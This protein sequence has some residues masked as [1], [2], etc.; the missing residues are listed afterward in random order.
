MLS[1]GTVCI[2]PAGHPYFP[3]RAPNWIILSFY[4]YTFFSPTMS[5]FVT[6]G[7]IRNKE[8]ALWPAMSLQQDHTEDSVQYCKPIYRGSPK[9]YSVFGTLEPLKGQYWVPMQWSYTLVNHV[10]EPCVCVLSETRQEIR[11]SPW[12]WWL[13]HITRSFPQ[14]ANRVLYYSWTGKHISQS[15]CR[16]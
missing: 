3:L 2:Y 12:L 5:F 4:F 13:W 14:K 8:S 16:A 9:A 10:V 6:L 11:Q 7:G 1:W 15:C